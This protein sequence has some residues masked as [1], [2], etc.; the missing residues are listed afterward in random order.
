M[1]LSLLTPSA[2]DVL[3]TVRVPAINS[4]WTF[5]LNNLGGPFLFRLSGFPSDWM[6][7]AVLLN[8]DN[9]TDVPF[10]VPTGRKQ[11]TGLRVVITKDVGRI[12]GTVSA[13]R[14][15]DPTDAIVVV[16]P[17]DA[18]HWMHGSRFIRTARPTA[19]GTYSITGLPAGDYLVVAERELMEGE[20]EDRQSLNVLASRAVRVSLKRGATE[21]VDL[22]VSVPR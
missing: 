21:A 17:E 22:K 14:G 5:T 7:D 20:W 19:A 6:L 8:D 11:V 16:F 4:D 2:E 18:Q 10:D 13:D 15:V 1:R 3:P 9:L 12:S